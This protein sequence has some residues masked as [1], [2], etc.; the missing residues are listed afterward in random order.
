MALPSNSDESWAKIVGWAWRI[1]LVGIGAGIAWYC[2][3]LEQKEWYIIPLGVLSIVLGLVLGY[4][5]Y[6]WGYSFSE[7]N[8]KCPNCGKPFCISYISQKTIS[9]SI[10]TEGG[11]VRKNG[12]PKPIYRYRVG[13]RGINWRCRNCGHEGYGEEKYKEKI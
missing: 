9:E 1:V 6:G 10:V 2:F 12:P 11:G 13:V 5:G 4:F 3:T 8:S 7:A